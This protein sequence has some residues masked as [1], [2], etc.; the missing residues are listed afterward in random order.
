MK[1]RLS[2]LFVIFLAVLMAWPLDGYSRK[3][4]KRK[5]T[6]ELNFV[7][8]DQLAMKARQEGCVV[9]AMTVN[10]KNSN[11]D[12]R[13]REGID[14]SHYQGHINWDQV[15]GSSKISYVYLKATEGASYVDDT[16]DRN[17]SEARRVGLS[18]GSYHFYRPNIDWREQLKNLTRKVK[19]SEQ[20]LVPI[21][22]I[23]HR[24]RVSESKFI[25]DLQEFVRHV[26]KHYGKKP[27]LYSY[28]N[29]YNRHLKGYFKDYHWMIAKYQDSKPFL[30]DGKDYIMW[31]YTQAGRMP[32]VKGN[33]DR[34]CIMQ[35]FDLYQLQL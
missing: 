7:E 29:F 21:I 9:R 10:Q 24:G 11:I 19:A 13:F 26:E 33:V 31:Q 28:Q 6:V 30:E 14:V 27:L 12:V 3:R 8:P 1:S 16:Y 32:G 25:R 4:N 17:L 2:S 34:S 35:G 23:E 18:V 15:A 22:D 5:S 20:D